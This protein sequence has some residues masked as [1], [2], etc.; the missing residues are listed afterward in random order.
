MRHF[1]KIPEEENFNLKL[2]VLQ[3]TTQGNGCLKVD[4]TS[5]DMMQIMM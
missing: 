3:T 1:L 5:C 4:V 2:D